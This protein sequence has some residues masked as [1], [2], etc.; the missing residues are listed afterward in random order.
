MKQGAERLSSPLE[1]AFHSGMSHLSD[2]RAAIEAK[3]VVGVVAGN[4]TTAA[5]TLDHPRVM[6]ITK[7]PNAV[8]G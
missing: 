5:K 8:A 6:A 4:L 7:M 1:V 2:L 3:V